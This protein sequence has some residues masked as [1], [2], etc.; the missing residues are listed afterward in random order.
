MR[1]E[2]AGVDEKVVF[3]DREGKAPAK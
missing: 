2:S 3:V 1:D